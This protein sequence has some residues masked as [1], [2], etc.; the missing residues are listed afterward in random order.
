MFAAGNRPKA[1]RPAGWSCFWSVSGG[2]HWFGF[3]R[4]N[5]SASSGSCYCIQV[6]R[7]VPLV[8][9]VAHHQRMVELDRTLWKPLPV[10]KEAR[11]NV[12]DG[13][14]ADTP[15]QGAQP[16]TVKSVCVAGHR[17]PKAAAL[18]ERRR[19]GY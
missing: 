13:Q 4:P 8:H 9:N 15:V 18:E 17:V 19:F 3:R 7:L 14:S 1:G 12:G 5:S 6:L 2:E 16:Q 10:G 11:M